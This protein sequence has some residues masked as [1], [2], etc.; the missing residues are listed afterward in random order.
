[1]YNQSAWGPGT[2]RDPRPCEKCQCH[3]HATQCIYDESIEAAKLSI[4]T[5]GRR[6]GG[7]VCVDC[8]VMAFKFL[9]FK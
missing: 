8:K 5:L 3:G 1:M 6:R 9:I 2:S 4:D 7:G